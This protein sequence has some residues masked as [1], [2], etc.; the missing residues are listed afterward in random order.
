MLQALTYCTGVNKN[1]VLWH[2]PAV[3]RQGQRCYELHLWK[4]LEENV[5]TRK[6]TS[7]TT[8][9]SQATKVHFACDHT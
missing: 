2:G 4:G 1:T 3:R 6:S 9:M 8:A 7:K 5:P